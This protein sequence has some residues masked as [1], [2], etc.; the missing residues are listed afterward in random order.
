MRVILV[1][2]ANGEE[3]E[4][5]RGK[6]RLWPIIARGQRVHGHH[7]SRQASTVIPIIRENVLP[8]SIVYTDSFQVYDVL[9]VS[10]LHHR[11]VNHSR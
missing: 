5:Q 4:A 2:D 8:D 6:L 7:S 10:V 1:G 11:R 9:D 3:A